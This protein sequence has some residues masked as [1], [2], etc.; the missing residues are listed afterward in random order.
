MLRADT[1]RDTVLICCCLSQQPICLPLLPEPVS[2]CFYPGGYGQNCCCPSLA[3]HCPCL[4]DAEMTSLSFEDAHNAYAG[5]HSS[6]IRSTKTLRS[7]PV[8]TAQVSGVQL[9]RPELRS[10]LHAVPLH[11]SS[12]PTFSIQK[13]DMEVIAI[14][15]LTGSRS[16]KHD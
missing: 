12:S 10:L 15:Y 16:S 4:E 1:D 9:A 7:I 8:G 3:D 13:C 5:A 6:P 2:D 11:T 14:P